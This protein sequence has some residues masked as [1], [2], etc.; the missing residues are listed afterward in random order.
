MQM[1]SNNTVVATLEDLPLS[2]LILP[3]SS[4]SNIVEDEE[5]DERLENMTLSSMSES[6]YH[7]HSEAAELT[8]NT[9]YFI[10]QD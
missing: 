4:L 10:V 7:S 3:S 5:L 2:S 9:L 6:E 8:P 1:I